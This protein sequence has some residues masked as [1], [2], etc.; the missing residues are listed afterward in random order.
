MAAVRL[1]RRAASRGRG[2]VLN[3]IHM[4]RCLGKYIWLLMVGTSLGG[5]LANTVLRRVLT[6]SKVLAK[7]ASKSGLSQAV[8]SSRKWPLM[9]AGIDPE[10]HTAWVVVQLPHSP[11]KS[12]CVFLAVIL[13]TKATSAVQFVLQPTMAPF[14]CEDSGRPSLRS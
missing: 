13:G 9:V 1:L 12:L 3:I 4:P 7:T 10:S 5:V 2:S 8:T 6:R 11:F 14:S